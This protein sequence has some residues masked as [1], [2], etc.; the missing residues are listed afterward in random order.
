MLAEAGRPGGRRMALLRRA[1]GRGTLVDGAGAA[2]LLVAYVALRTVG[3]SHAWLELWYV[4]ATAFSV[5][6]PYG[7]LLLV[8]PVGMFIGPYLLR[9]GLPAWTIWVIAWTAGVLARVLHALARDRAEVR[10]VYLSPPML[11]VLFLL[12]A[13]AFSVVTTWRHFGRA[14]GVDALY[15]WLWGPGTLLLALLAVAWLVRDART[16][17]LV[18]AIATGVVAGVVSLVGWFAPGALRGGPLGWLMGPQTDMTRLHGVTYL[19]TGLEALLIIPVAILA[20]AALYAADRR[21]RAVAGLVLVP[22]G[23]A[24]WFTYNRAGLLAFFV[25]AVVAAWHYRRRLGLALAG[26]GLAGGLLLLP[27]YLAIRGDA[28]G[29]M[30]TIAPGQV[31]APSDQMR[32][33]AWSAA[34]GMWRDAPILGRGFW[35][36]FRLHERY[37]SPALD[38][39]HNDWLRLFAEGGLLAGVAGV[40]F[41]VVVGWWL[42]RGRGWL[43]RATLAALVCW[44]LALSFNN[45]MSYDQVSIPLAVVVATGIA[46]VARERRSAGSTAAVLPGES[47]GGE[48]LAPAAEIGPGVAAGSDARTEPFPHQ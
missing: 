28:V 39:P 21:L 44:A 7:G 13:S 1:A 16:R 33:Q 35:S 23:L 12:A 32:L 34:A 5:A 22:L 40:A 20:M 2:V 29:A 30:G 14:I 9:P 42:A 27:R 10:R 18:L 8:I 19:A 15:R 38:A 37:G 46:L 24:I 43:A 47:A 48:S 4:A 17:P 41:L 36:F 11:A 25:I 45:I 31:L 3:A 6:R 26:V